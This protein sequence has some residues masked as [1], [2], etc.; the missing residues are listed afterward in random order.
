MSQMKKW[1]SAKVVITALAHQSL[2]LLTFFLG[3]RYQSFVFLKLGNFLPNICINMPVVNWL[4][5]MSFLCASLFGFTLLFYSSF[6]VLTIYSTS[7]FRIRK[8]M[9]EG[10]SYRTALHCLQLSDKAGSRR[11]NTCQEK[12]FLM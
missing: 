7:S 6:T 1:S 11:F 2:S 12:G 10:P 4:T 3:Q 5:D 8:H 9:M